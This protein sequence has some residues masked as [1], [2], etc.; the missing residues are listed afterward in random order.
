MK[1]LIIPEDFTKDQYM[2]KPIV[3]AMMDYLGRPRARVEVCRNPRLRGIRQ[4]TR[5][6]EI[7]SILDM[8]PMIDLFL[9]LVDR[10]GESG[11]RLTLNNIEDQA[12][13]YMNNPHKKLLAENAWQELEVWV[14][15][16]LADL[17]DNWSWSTI[18][19]EINPKEN[20]FRPYAQSHGMLESPGEGRKILGD[21][22]AKNY[23]RLR[24]LCVEDLQSLESNI[25]QWLES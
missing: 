7:R 17:P 5:W 1:V 25:K 19:S 24:S 10:D 12:A 6:E 16:G 21:Q 9:L 4:A 15:A 13:D 11:R 20:Y 3:S 23:R 18:R 2:I 22:A 8:Y 14:L